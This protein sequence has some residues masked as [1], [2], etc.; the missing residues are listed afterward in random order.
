V[1]LVEWLVALA[2]GSFVAVAALS[3]YAQAA[4]GTRT[5]LA[6]QQ[7]HENA[8]YAAD[9][10]ERE[11]RVAG[12]AG[13]APDLALADGATSADAPVPA[14]LRIA[15]CAPAVAL[16]L[17]RAVTAADARYAV[18]AAIPVGCPPSPH[19]RAVESADTLTVRR[20][21]LE[22]GRAERGRLQL[23]TTRVRSVLFADGAMP[24]GFDAGEVHDLEAA[25]YYVAADSS[26]GRGIPSLRRKRL[27]GGATGPRFED[28]ELAVGVE[29]L[30]VEFGVDGGDDDEAPERYVVPGA[31][32]PGDVP[33]T[34]RFWLRVRADAPDPTWRDTQAR[35]YADR[36]V[37]GA[38]DAHRRV[39]VER[40]VFLRNLRRQ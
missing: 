5:S 3:V 27:V 6:V 2:L 23:A 34:V 13:L 37:R 30:Q 7:L 26:S 20:A 1:G 29:D 10:L 35:A 21:R 9:L 16:D 14:A 39:V 36:T 32:D 17:E 24:A 8:R 40:T 28:E 25:V 19:G 31:E 4:A 38:G 33:R 12:Y 11:L 22:P 15:G 18:E